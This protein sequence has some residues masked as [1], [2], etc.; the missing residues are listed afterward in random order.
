M[1]FEINSGRDKTRVVSSSVSAITLDSKGNYS[2]GGIAQGTIVKLYTSG[3]ARDVVAA[4]AGDYPD[5]VVVSSSKGNGPGLTCT[6]R[7]EGVVK[8]IAGGA[9]SLG[10]LLKADASGHA[11]TKAADGATTEYLIGQALEAATG[12]GDLISVQMRIGTSHATS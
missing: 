3:S 5:G 4:G 7:D 10:D 11:V 8:V 6:V 12:S 9:I 1:P 2:S